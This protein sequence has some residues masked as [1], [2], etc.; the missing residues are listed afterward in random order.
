MD[1]SGESAMEELRK[2]EADLRA[3]GE[4]RGLTLKLDPA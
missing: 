4:Q 2:C 1:M 3:Y